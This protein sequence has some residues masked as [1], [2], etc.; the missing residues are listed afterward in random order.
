MTASAG[1]IALGREAVSETDAAAAGVADARGRERSR[2]RRAACVVT[3]ALAVWSLVAWAAAR[4]L[5]VREE[6]ER[7]DALVVM[8]G[9]AD[10]AERAAEAVRLFREGR[11]PV[12]LLTDDGQ[13][14]PWSD[15]EQRNP[16]FH[17]RTRAELR[18]AGV[19]DEAVLLLAGTV[20]GT[21]EE[22]ALLR[23]E[24]DARGL[25]SL[26]VVTSAYHT[27]RALRTLRA[28]FDGSGV[29]LGMEPAGEA[30]GALWWLGATGWRNVAGEYFKTVYYL[31]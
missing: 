18:R 24:A 5:V 20:T 27:R 11:A 16:F 25:R 1:D 4:A 6:L 13:R 2:V 22:S 26:L 29:R 23:Q 31:F 15:E 12:I 19:P 7:A 9:S 17:E 21:R 10:Y 30:P 28:A 14:G 3:V 8:S